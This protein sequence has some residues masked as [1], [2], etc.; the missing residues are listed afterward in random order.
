MPPSL[1]SWQHAMASIDL[2]SPARPQ[3]ELWGYWIPEPGLLLRP[4]NPDRLHR[5]LFNWLRMRHAWLYILRLRDARA[6]L[7]PTQWWRDFLYGDPGRT[8]GPSTTNNARRT[9]HMK[10]VFGLAFQEAHFEP[11]CTSPVRWFDHTLSVLDTTFCPMIIWEVCELSFRYELLA[12]DRLLVPGRDGNLGE[13]HRDELLGQIFSNGSVY[14]ITELPKEGVGLSALLP[15]R[16]VRHL[17]AF[18]QVMGRWPR[19]PPSFYDPDHTITINMH[20]DMIVVRERE[21]VRFYIHTFFEQ[22]GRAPIV[23]H[24][25]PT[26]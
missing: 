6:F 22:S 24:Q 8:S 5:Y 10:E 18:R 3:S 11:S 12:L 1:P 23:P 25:V 7:V 14:C 26:M 15:R 17:E 4:Q 21:L 13:E 9:A 20:D 16:R 19:C 2:S